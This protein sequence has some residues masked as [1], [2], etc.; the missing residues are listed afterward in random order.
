MLRRL[1]ADTQLGEIPLTPRRGMYWDCRSIATPTIL[2]HPPMATMNWR[3][4][5]AVLASYPYDL[6]DHA[7]E[8]QFFENPAGNH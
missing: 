2:I 3:D 4:S 8:D 1:R 5:F 7:A 6:F